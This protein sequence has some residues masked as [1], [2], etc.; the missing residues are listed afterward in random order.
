MSQAVEI[1]VRCVPEKEM[2]FDTWEAKAFRGGRILY[3]SQHTWASPEC[4]FYEVLETLRQMGDVK[5][6][7]L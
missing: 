4:A 3:Q 7:G 6:G 1:Y 5:P 2:P